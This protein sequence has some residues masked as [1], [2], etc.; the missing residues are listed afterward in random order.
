MSKGS[1]V[2]LIFVLILLAAASAYGSEGTLKDNFKNPPRECSLLPFWVWNDTLEKDK[3]K[4]Q[5]DQMVEKGIYGGF[6]HARIGLNMGKTPYFSQGWWDAMDT[7]VNYGKEVGF[8]T[9]LYDED[10]WPSGSAGGRTIAVNP[11]EFS[12]KGLVYSEMG[13]DGPQNIKI[14]PAK[15]RK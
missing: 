7:A 9:W 11:D 12:Q 13:I 4:W 2:S 6:I 8:Y 10:R 3:L 5:I 15:N 1:K 14:Q